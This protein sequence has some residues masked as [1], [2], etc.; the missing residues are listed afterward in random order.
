MSRIAIWRKQ[1]DLI[2]DLAGD[3]EAILPRLDTIEA[4][5]QLAKVLIRLDSVLLTH[6]TSEDA[7]LYPA[8]IDGSD[9]NAADVASSFKTEMGGIV[10]SYSRFKETWSG[11]AA[12]HGNPGW[13]RRDWKA[14]L[15]A[16]ANRIERENTMLYPLAERAER[17]G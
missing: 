8:M 6:L 9:R 14:L 16:L 10:H 12:I 13:F 17:V 4:A 3:V 7:F 15:A 11:A 1:H 5:E 2:V